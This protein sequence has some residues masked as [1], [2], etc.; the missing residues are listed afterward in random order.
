MPTPE[1]ILSGLRT[2][3]NDWQM[4]AIIWHVYFAV[5]ALSLILGSRPSKRVAGILLGLPLLSVSALAW[6]S[7]NP[8]NGMVFTLTGTAL[9]LISSRLPRENVRVAPLWAVVVGAFMFFFG[10]VYPHFLDV[11]TFLPYLYSAPTGLIPCPT[12]SIV[13]G[14]SVVLGG[15]GTR[16]WSIVLSVTGIF[17]SVFGAL[18][19]GVTL[20][21]VL[22]LGAL[23]VVITVFTVTRRGQAN[24][25]K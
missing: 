10:W 24:E 21:W 18:R 1:Q 4:L 9:L 16:T 3:S 17:Y 13:I 15:L 6:A 7:A 20:D 11:P 23:M 2:I 19:L 8:F 14:L 12:L 25:I 5:L 22:L